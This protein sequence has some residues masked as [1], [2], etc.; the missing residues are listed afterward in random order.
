MWLASSSCII[1][2]LIGSCQISVSTTSICNE[3]AELINTF[4]LNSERPP[5]Q[6]SHWRTRASWSSGLFHAISALQSEPKT[7]A[8]RD[9]GWDALIEKEKPND[10]SSSS[11]AIASCE[12]GHTV[13]ILTIPGVVLSADRS[14]LVI[15]RHDHVDCWL[16]ERCD[17]DRA[18]LQLAES[19]S[20]Q[21]IAL[22]GDAGV[23]P[24]SYECLHA[25]LSIS[26]GSLRSNNS[27]QTCGP[28]IFIKLWW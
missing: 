7:K 20:S 21:W 9:L 25:F 19:L 12:V 5:S 3:N 24:K 13:K 15:K 16:A 10:I 2:R 14:S 23:V 26:L 4:K 28:M 8:P 1:C 11:I 18:S 6:I 22:W 27:Y 17:L